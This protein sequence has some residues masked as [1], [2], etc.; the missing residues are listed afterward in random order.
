MVSEQNTILGRRS[1]R[2]AGFTFAE[3]AFAFVIMATVAMALVSHVSSLY[4]RNSNHQDR[5]FAYAKASSILAELQ[6]YVNR[7]DDASANSLDSLDDGA[8]YNTTLS[9]AVEGGKS[10]APDHP[11]SGNKVGAGGWMW[12]R[13]ITV[14]PFPGL[15]NRNVRYVTVKIFRNRGGGRYEVLADLSGVVNSIGTAF[16]PSQAYDVYLIA[17]ENIPGWWVH[18][19]AI[20]PFI[21]STITDL[22]A[23]NPGAKIRTHWITKA[24]YGRNQLYAPYVNFAKDS[25]ENIPSVYVYPGR[26]PT[27]SASSYY[28]VPSLIK[29]RINLDGVL[30][31]GYDATKN[32][33]PYALADRFN[34]AMRYE[35]ERAY[36]EAR[37]KAGL[38]KADEPTLR[39]LLEDMARDPNRYHNAILVNLHGELLPMP[40]LRNFSDAARSPAGTLT[41]GLRVVTHG[42][43]LRFNRASTV[44]ASENVRLRVYA[45][46]TNPATA[47][48]SIDTQLTGRKPITLQV[49]DANLTKNINGAGTGPVTLRVKRLRGGVD[50]GN[51][52]KDYDAAFNP[53]PTSPNLSHEMYFTAKWVDDTGFGGE[54]Y[55]LVKLYNTPSIAPVIGTAP[56]DRGLHSSN[57]LYG[58]DYIPCSTESANDFSRT[59]G[60]TGA[61]PKNTARWQIEI[62]AAVLDG[63]TTGS[64]LT[65]EDHVLAIRTRIGDDLDTGRAFPLP[66]DPGNLSTTYVYWTDTVADVPMTERAQ[67][68]GD[69]RHCP[70]ADL[71]DGGA[72]F[73]NGYNWFFD[74]FADG[75]NN[76]QPQ[77]PG[78][79]PL[80]LR[81]GW[82][83]RLELDWPRYAQLVRTSITNSEAIYTTLTGFSYYYIGLGGEIG[84]DAANGYPQSIP[85]NLRPFG[86]DAGTGHIDTIAFGGD[87]ALRRQKIVRQSAASSYWW[88]I[89]WLGELY[90]DSAASQWLASGNLPAGG[91]AG[92]FHQVPRDTITLRL[93][94]GTRLIPT[95]SAT[96]FEGCTS[97]F[98]TSNGAGTFHHQFASGTEGVLEGAGLE[99]AANYNFPMPSRTKI[100]RPFGI[101]LTGYGSV[102]DEWFFPGDYPRY[103]TTIE[104]TYYRHDWGPEGSAVVGLTTPGGTR[105][106]HV[107][108]NGLDTTIESGTSFIAKYAVLSLMH[109]YF[110][111]GHPSLPNHLTLPPRLEIMS[112]TEIT[113][114]NDP[115]TIPITWSTTWRRWDGKKYT[116]SFAAS[117]SQSESELEYVVMYSNDGGQTFRFV[118]DDK[119]A[120]PGTRPDAAHLIADGGAGN[121][122]LVWNTSPDSKFPQGS[123]LIRV[124]A[125]RKS[126]AL[127]YSYHQ[128]KIFV[129]R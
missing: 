14:R 21:E 102:G 98:N 79:S 112:P 68:L 3:L 67:F 124:E 44:S 43:Q 82:R 86:T 66:N 61:G 119:V 89:Y 53:A 59:L 46:R 48:G 12:A 57:R 75:T 9:I 52:N 85:I 49:M 11:L 65:L 93:P 26:M 55:T 106:A 15:D 51:A 71:K 27:G 114:L 28:Y 105:T 22:E 2:E 73:P 72:N 115:A 35:D 34:H 39:L 96:V 24:S 126:E 40:A 70:Y 6:S 113:E 94:F 80:R 87:A 41:K 58:Y 111:A 10:V 121:E 122:T 129:Q 125:Y 36:F 64:G 95:N 47:M 38:E 60:A 32:P 83:G 33:L 103:G 100:S 120:T 92:T 56:D 118:Q 7:T 127:H 54:K 109:S 23:R 88:G 97:V 45:Y 4:R 107:V 42:E 110:E 123:Y 69:P 78:F 37:R 117:F 99:L 128:Q 5:V 29:G 17:I 63:A 8:S 19:D 77:W 101:D 108:V 91:G 81:D 104:R 20:R 30:T 74:N 62:P 84:Y 25:K 50:P 31:N 16:P 18:M 76:A 13:R 1:V 90:P 116:Q